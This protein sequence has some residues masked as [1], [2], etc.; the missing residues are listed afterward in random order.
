MKED[1]M[2]G[3][4]TEGRD[5]LVCKFRQIKLLFKFLACPMSVKLTANRTMDN[6]LQLDMLLPHLLPLSNGVTV[7]TTSETLH[8]SQVPLFIRRWCW[9]WC[10]CWCQL[11]SDGL[12]VVFSLF[13]LTDNL[14]WS[15]QQ[16]RIYPMGQPLVG[17]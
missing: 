5:N 2:N 1:E 11:M 3:N 14:R 7:Q 15:N 10:W 16:L 6:N 13:Y 17:N 4:S 12:G 9:C 8:K